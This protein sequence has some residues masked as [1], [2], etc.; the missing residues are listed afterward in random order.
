MKYSGHI[1]LINDK[2]KQYNIDRESN[3]LVIVGDNLSGKTL[4]LNH[5]EDK[6]RDVSKFTQIYQY[7]EY[8]CQEEKSCNVL[9][10][11]LKH[12]FPDQN[13]VLSYKKYHVLSYFSAAE[14]NGIPINIINSGVIRL[15]YILIEILYQTKKCLLIDDIE[16]QLSIEV[17]KKL[18][19]FIKEHY[20]TN[21][22][23]EIIITT[24]SPF[25]LDSLISYTVDIGLLLNEP[26]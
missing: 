8:Y 1:R 11:Y 5:I 23:K 10:N 22:D 24:H 9:N 15:L 13:F 7:L 17:Q 26:T 21:K 12:F 4:L 6:N 14:L 3:I 20:E 25:I 16:T 19:L 18:S 2:V